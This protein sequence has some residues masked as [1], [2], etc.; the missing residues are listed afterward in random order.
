MFGNDGDDV[1]YLSNL[2]DFAGGGAGND[3]IFGS[4]GNSTIWGRAGADTVHSGSGKDVISGG[5]GADVFVFA[6]AAAIGIGVA[7]DVI[8]DFAQGVDDINL[9]ALDTAFNGTAGQLG[10]GARSFYYFATGGLLIGDQ[11]GDGVADWVLELS[12]A[13]AI[14]AG[15]FLLQDRQE[16]AKDRRRSRWPCWSVASRFLATAQRGLRLQESVIG[17]TPR[18]RVSGAKMKNSIISY[19][20]H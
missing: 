16:R 19:I 15:D 9:T 3:L 18:G 13:P 12:G 7:R 1:I 8:S 4:A 17:T 11:T 10:G 2:G 20:T 5:P 14:T 6:S